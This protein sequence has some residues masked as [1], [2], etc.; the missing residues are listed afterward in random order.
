MKIVGGLYL[1]TIIA[2][3][4]FRWSARQRAAH[5]AAGSD[6]MEPDGGS[7]PQSVPGTPETLTFSEVVEAFESAGEPP[8]E[9][10]E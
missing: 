8:P 6:D 4:F 5:G 3:V 9:R 1:W 2:A 7:V 10:R